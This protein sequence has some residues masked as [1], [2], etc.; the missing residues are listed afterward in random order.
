MLRKENLLLIPFNCFSFS[1]FSCKF[2][3]ASS[4]SFVNLSI[5]ALKYVDNIKTE[6]QRKNVTYLSDVI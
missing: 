6:R 1:S 3:F 4:N 2:F 5:R